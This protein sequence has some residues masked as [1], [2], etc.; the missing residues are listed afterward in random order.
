MR[1][2]AMNEAKGLKSLRRGFGEDPKIVAWFG[3][4]ATIG[5][6]RHEDARL[7]GARRRSGEKAIPPT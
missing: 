3:T 2:R 1:P 5:L 7:S 6:S 4:H